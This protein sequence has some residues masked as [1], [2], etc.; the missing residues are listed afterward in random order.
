MFKSVR[1]GKTRLST[2]KWDCTAND[3][4]HDL[5][6]YNMYCTVQLGLPS[7]KSTQPGKITV[8]PFQGDYCVVLF[9]LIK[10]LL[11]QQ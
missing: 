2:P 5:S 8:I 10:P 6:W 7:V 9:F 11:Q 4:L 1:L 3:P